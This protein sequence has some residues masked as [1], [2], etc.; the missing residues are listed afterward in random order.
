LL[1]DFHRRE[2]AADSAIIELYPDNREEVV[3]DG[4]SSL[5]AEIQG[6]GDR[7]CSSKANDRIGN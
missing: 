6:D 4:L 7:R 3:Q 5:E 2:K 1:N